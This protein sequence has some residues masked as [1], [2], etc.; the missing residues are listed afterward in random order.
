MSYLVN[1]LPFFVSILKTTPH[2]CASYN[3]VAI[4]CVNFII[5]YNMHNHGEEWDIAGAIK[6]FFLTFSFILVS[7]VFLSSPS[8]CNRFV[9]LSCVSFLAGAAFLN[10]EQLFPDSYAEEI[11]LRFIIIYLAYFS[12]LSINFGIKQDVSDRSLCFF[13]LF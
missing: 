10:S 11:Y 13:D 2:I 1:N 8:C 3:I 6:P 9:A 5:Y 12:F 4:S 7:L